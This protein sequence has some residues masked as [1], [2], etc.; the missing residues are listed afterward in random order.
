MSYHTDYYYRKKAE[1][2]AILGGKCVICGTTEQLEFDH[3]DPT[4]KKFAISKLLNVSH[5]A[6]IDEL[7][8]CQLL[9]NGCH[10]IKTKKNKDGYSSRAKGERVSS[11]V[12]TEQIVIAILIKRKSG[13]TLTELVRE[14]GY[15][16]ATI[17]AV[18]SNRSWKH[19][20]RQT[21][22]G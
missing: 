15:K 4:T 22:Y 5:Q 12:L 1:F 21:D 18:I 19:I 6:A 20:D 17:Y 3:I 7:D 10:K 2:I 9:C 8:K 13:S 14:F 11:A 16:K